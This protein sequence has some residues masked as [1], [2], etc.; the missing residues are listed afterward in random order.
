[1]AVLEEDKN[2]S[3]HVLV[4]NRI[5]IQN[6]INSPLK[7]TQRIKVITRGRYALLP[8]VNVVFNVVSRILVYVLRS[9]A[10]LHNFRRFERRTVR[11]SQAAV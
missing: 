2:V 8:V 3:E 9:V 1:M 7:S 11:V 6:T 10:E 5:D 4:L